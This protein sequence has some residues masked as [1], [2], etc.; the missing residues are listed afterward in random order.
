MTII[1]RNL[2]AGFEETYPGTDV[3]LSVSRDDAVLRALQAGKLI[4][5]PLVAP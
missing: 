1:N 2:E 4:W 3:I 5:R